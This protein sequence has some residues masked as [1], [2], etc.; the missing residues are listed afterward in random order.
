MALL[1]P[2]KTQ[3]KDGREVVIRCA[4]ESDASA[5]L[6]FIKINLADGGGMIGEPDEFTKTE[7]DEKAWIKALNDDPKQLLLVGDADGIIVGIIDFHIQK[8]RRVAHWGSF[9]M[10]VRPGWRSFGVGNALLDG[11]LVWARSVPEIEKI[12]LAVRADNHRAIALY[13]KY[14]FAQSGCAKDYLKM[15]DG[16]YIDDLNMEMFVRS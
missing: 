12:T 1:P 11:L 10:S 8:R 5:L 9:G 6:E 2:K 4:Q 14:G 15:S 3:L 13:K 7:D 16:S